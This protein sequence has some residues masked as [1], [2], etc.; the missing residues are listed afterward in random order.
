[1]VR[2]CEM[3]RSEQYLNTVALSGGVFQNTVLTE[4]ALK[5]LRKRG[6]CVYVNEAVPP[7]DGSIS[8]GQTY[9][10]LMEAK[11]HVCCGT[12]KNN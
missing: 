7:N 11:N 1:M 4:Q 12:R 9:I 10:G 5:L 2:V 8:L 6:F 3:I